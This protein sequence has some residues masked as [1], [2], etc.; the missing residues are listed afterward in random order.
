[1]TAPAELV[2]EVT[3]DDIAQG[4]RQDPCRCA[5]ALAVARLTGTPAQEG[6]LA[7]T[8]SQVKIGRGAGRWLNRY[9]L[10]YEAEEFI[11]DFDGG[12][13]VQPFTFTARLRGAS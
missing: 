4:V 7:I 5:I 13:E 6:Y 10:P 11:E 1:M 12:H 2:I 9:R 8:D 3:A